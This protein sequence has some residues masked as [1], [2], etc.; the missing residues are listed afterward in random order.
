MRLHRLEIRDF[1]GV[2]HLVLDDL[3]DTGVHV[4]HGPNERGKST[5]VAALHAVLFTP[6]RK[7]GKVLEAMR[8]VG[9]DRPPSVAAE[10]S[11][12]G[13][14][15]TVD[16]RYTGRSG[17]STEIRV[18]EGPGAPAQ[19]AGREAEDWLAERVQAA[20]LQDLWGA[21]TAEQGTVP[22]ALELAKVPQMS[23]A[24]AGEPAT[25][26]PAADA[27]GEAEAAAAAEILDRARAEHA[28]LLTPTGRYNK[29]V[30]EAL[31]APE[32]IGAELAGLRERRR[33][34][35]DWVA[36][37][38][39][40]DARIR[41]LRNRAPR[42]RELVAELAEAAEAA[43]G[44]TG[45]AEAA[46]AAVRQ[47][48][49]E[50]EAAATARGTRE[51]LVAEL[52][53]R[54]AA[55]D[56]ATAELA[57][58]EEAAEAARA[59]VAAARA[60]REAAAAAIADA[61]A[62]RV[63][64][65]S[66]AAHLAELA[67]A[68]AARGRRAAVAEAT[69]ARDAAAARLDG[70][71]VTAELIAEIDRADSRA[72]LARA[73]LEQAA[74]TVR[75]AAD[76]AREVLLDGAGVELGEAELV[77]PVTARTVIGVDGVTVTVDP[78]ADAA[79]RAAE[80]VAADRALAGLL[81]RAGVAG[82]DEA[83]A[84]AARRAAA[85]EG[86]AEAER[87]LA[88]ARAAGDA[89]ADRELLR[90]IYGSAEPGPEAAPVDRAGAR[91]DAWRGAG[92]PPEPPA[93]ADAARAAREA[94]EADLA[95]AEAAE[96]GAAGR[97]RAAETGAA[98]TRVSTARARREDALREADQAAAALAGA[99][100]DAADEA[101]AEALAAAAGALAEAE[102][103]AAAVAAEVAERD[104]RD[105]ILRHEAERTRLNAEAMDLERAIA[106]RDGL[107]RTVDEATGLDERIARAEGELAHARQRA[108]SLVERA[109]ALRMLVEVLE[110]A[111]EEI[112]V[113]YAAPLRDTLTRLAKPVFGADVAFDLD[114]DLGIVSRT[115]GGRTVA[116]AALSGGAREQLDILLR[117]AAAMILDGGESAPIILDDALGATDPDRLAD[118]N[119]A[120]D[121]AGRQAQVIVLTC[122]PDRYGMRPVRWLPIDSLLTP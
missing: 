12:D 112:R 20:G 79:D 115:R 51:R 47:R 59:A 1:R 46:E 66:D 109:D 95:A 64:A 96:E 18:L 48:R 54:E 101:L 11:L 43:R 56:R 118:M 62:R 52:R 65:E 103:A 82:V 53:A 16:K 58:A 50:H 32:D 77:R 68:E 30:A 26:D 70:P 105:T 2:R 97:L 37:I 55:R 122:D 90:R 120:L 3:A 60:D 33:E 23:R 44:L 93:D 19:Y 40:L 61:R 25:A 34:F 42:Q 38:E 89:D 76:P 36:G 8:S 75:L 104:P 71:A 106:R 4:I 100:A 67:A 13:R 73:V 102:R 92:E 121:I 78:A 29:R 63:L 9:V 119:V 57:A 116:F 21:F 88:E 27:A 35:D 110:E 28:E 117:L 14:R 74:P 84:A 91:R 94:A 80:A 111:R 108:E 24:A 10:L 7:T 107:Q 6:A 113:A 17:A 22:G 86:L 41:R 45:R 85:E 39:R 87:A 72:R 99:R 83:R 69:G 81:E 31:R 15:F 49:L 98:L 114:E 5:I